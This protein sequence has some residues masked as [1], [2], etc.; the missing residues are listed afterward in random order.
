MII[1][2]ENLILC[3]NGKEAHCTPIVAFQGSGIFAEEDGR[4]DVRARGVGGMDEFSKG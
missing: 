1:R 2:P 4:E 3:H